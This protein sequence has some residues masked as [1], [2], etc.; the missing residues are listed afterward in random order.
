MRKLIALASVVAVGAIVTASA[1]LAEEKEE[2]KKPMSIHD[3][4]E[5]GFKGGKPLF[6]AVTNK[7]KDST[8]EE[9]KKFLGML[10][11]MAKQ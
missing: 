4:M 7:K 9:N 10:K 2:E 8:E 6:R 5:K 3:V 1:S 11:D